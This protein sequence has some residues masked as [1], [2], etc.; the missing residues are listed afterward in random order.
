MSLSLSGGGQAEGASR[1]VALE[2]FAG[3]DQDSDGQLDF[4]E[5]TK[6]AKILC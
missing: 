4:E 2:V 3:F 1:P 5:F 6:I